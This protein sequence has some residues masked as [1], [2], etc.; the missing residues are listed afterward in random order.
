MVRCLAYF[1]A[2]LASVL[3]L[4]YFMYVHTAFACFGCA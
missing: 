2:L 3:F 4:P 1:T